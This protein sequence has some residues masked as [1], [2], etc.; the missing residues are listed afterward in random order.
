MNAIPSP[1]AFA[2]SYSEGPPYGLPVGDSDPEAID[3]ARAAAKSADVGASARRREASPKTKPT[4]QPLE[5]YG[6]GK[7]SGV[8]PREGGVSAVVLTAEDSGSVGTVAG[9]MD[10]A[11][12]SAPG[13]RQLLR[14]KRAERG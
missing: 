6:L 7:G 10:D 14:V 1:N 11:P 9:A 8:R 2:P 12:D 4:E 5:G 13:S 3:A